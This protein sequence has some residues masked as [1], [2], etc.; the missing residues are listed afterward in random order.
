MI[1]GSHLGSWHSD[2][3]CGDWSLHWKS[4][5]KASSLL[6]I[7]SFCEIQKI[8]SITRS[9]ANLFFATTCQS[10]G[11][12]LIVNCQQMKRSCIQTTWTWW[13]R[14]NICKQ[15]LGKWSIA[16]NWFCK[17]WFLKEDFVSLKM[18]LKKDHIDSQFDA[19][20]IELS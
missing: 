16:I 18:P 12:T 13:S 14:G 17:K 6:N 3:L 15:S 8:F 2:D 1:N 11:S 19:C 10:R 7:L 5:D 4:N 20:S 9:N